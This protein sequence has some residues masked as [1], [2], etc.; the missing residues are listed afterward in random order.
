MPGYYL[1][2]PAAVPG[3]ISPEA[4]A[5]IDRANGRQH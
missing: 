3:L 4:Q 2:R 1:A 5:V